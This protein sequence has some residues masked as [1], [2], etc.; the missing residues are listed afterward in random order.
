MSGSRNIMTMENKNDVTIPIWVTRS[1]AFQIQVGGLE[2]LTIH[3]TKPEFV[4]VKLE[5]ND[6]DLPFGTI[7]VQEGLYVRAGWE[8]RIPKYRT[9]SVS[10]GK[11]IGYDNPIAH[12]IWD[13]VC[14]HFHH[15]PFE[16]WAELEKSGDSK[17]EDFLLEMEISISLVR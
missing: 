7:S 10:V 14:E 4:L 12:H 13:R 16:T 9:G 17:R 5:D 2:R 1:S 15:A 3:F 8:E 11:W 6:R